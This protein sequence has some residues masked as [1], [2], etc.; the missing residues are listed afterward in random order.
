MSGS[1]WI[2]G[3][4]VEVAMRRGK[5]GIDRKTRCKM[6]HQKNK[7]KDLNLYKNSIIVY[8]TI[9][10]R[11]DRFFLILLIFVL[12][13]SGC[14]SD[15]DNNHNFNHSISECS[16]I[17]MKSLDPPSTLLKGESTAK[18]FSLI[19][20]NNNR[21][22][23]DYTQ[24]HISESNRGKYSINQVLDIWDY[25]VDQWCYEGH[26]D[27]YAYYKS[28]SNLIKGKIKDK[29]QGNCVNFATVF[30]ASIESL[31]G[32]SRVVKVVG[33]NMDWHVYPEIFIGSSENEIQ[34][35]LDYIKK[36]YSTQNIYYHRTYAQDLEKN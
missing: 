11:M 36:R 28:A 33:Q 2:N 1:G 17:S 34:P 27:D 29:F 26:P 7:K 35:T 23:N 25:T 30:S 16:T 19:I 13:T 31:G 21:I 9:L 10:T 8:M 15:T 6:K 20:D 3:Y 12:F 4:V 18:Q 14:L 32:R 24:S 22:V 5:R